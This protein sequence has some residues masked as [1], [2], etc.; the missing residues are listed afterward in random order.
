MG[1]VYI[2]GPSQ[3][4]GGAV[5]SSTALVGRGGMTFPSLGQGQ[6][7]WASM[8]ID[9]A[10]KSPKEEPCMM[11]PCDFPSAYGCSCT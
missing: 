3:D 1:E 11:G 8:S 10:M 9:G 2:T 5:E 7:A 4:A 6:Q